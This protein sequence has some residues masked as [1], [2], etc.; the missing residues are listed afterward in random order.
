MNGRAQVR[1]PN[2]ALDLGRIACFSSLTSQQEQMSAH[3]C[4]VL[5]L[6]GGMVGLSIAHQ[7]IERGITRSI[8]ILDKSLN[9]D[10]T[11]QVATVAY[12][13]ACTTSQVLSGPK[14][15]LKVHGASACGSKSAAY[16]S[17]PAG[18]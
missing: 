9:L 18:R 13:A 11:A 4:D 2:S 8:T 12:H 16:P 5:I 7:L 17:T 3:S 10:F 1:I 14:S 6:G 15:A